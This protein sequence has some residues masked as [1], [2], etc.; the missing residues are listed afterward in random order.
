MEI[1]IVSVQHVSHRYSVQWAVK[2]ISFDL[3]GRG[4]YGLLGANGAG[5]STIMNIICGV[6]NQTKGDVL[7][8]GIN[9]LTHP[10][11]AKKK[12]GFLPQKP[13]LQ[14][15]LTVAEF[16]DHAAKMRLMP[17]NAI[18]AAIDEV[19]N[20]CNL[21][22]FRNRIINNLSGGYQQ[23]V[24]IAQAIIHKPEFVV[25]DEPTNGLDPNQ[26][27]EIRS[28]I[29]EIAEERTV[30]L[31]THILQEVQAVCDQIWMINDGSIVFS[32]TMNEFDN[33]ILPASLVVSLMNPPAIEELLALEGVQQ[34]EAMN[35]HKFRIRYSD[36][37]EV[38][39]QLVR[40]S[41]R[42]DW[43]ISELFLEKHSLDN[44]F[45]ELSRKKP[46]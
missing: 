34:V 39:D 30:V 18:K 46:A 38:T 3:S 24:G 1:P 8:K 2:D 32:G 15:E 22:H 28:L 25:M 35:G 17:R 14:P 23:R 13:P 21:T 16:L 6:L 41:A 26:I 19:M 7:I 36:A 29:K 33:Y 4:V 43:R 40:N 44:I 20:K 10:V 12:I 31:S 11:E 42:H 27:I 45:S 9:L 5:K 37:Q